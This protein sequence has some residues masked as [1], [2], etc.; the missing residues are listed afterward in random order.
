MAV[1]TAAGAAGGT[2]TA[3]LEE[4]ATMTAAAAGAV[5]GVAAIVVATGAN[6]DLFLDLFINPGAFLNSPH[7]LLGAV[8]AD[9]DGFGLFGFDHLADLDVDLF[10][11]VLVG[12]DVH[13][14][15]LGFSA[16]SGDRNRAGAGFVLIDATANGHGNL[17]ALADGFVAGTTTAIA[18]GLDATA[19]GA[20]LHAGFRYRAGNTHREGAGFHLGFGD[21]GVD[22]AFFLLVHWHAHG[23]ITSLGHPGRGADLELADFVLPFRDLN[24]DFDLLVNPLGD[25]A[26]DFNFL[27]FDCWGSS[28]NGAATGATA[29]TATIAGACTGGITPAVTTLTTT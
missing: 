2:A 29:W 8:G 7:F 15:L 16:I 26:G 17:A 3:T 1:T 6:S 27:P 25:T 14:D 22:H 9:L 24:G 12:A 4:A 23:A 20:V 5:A 28:D 19:G 13:H 18:T 21:A 11:A 10:Y